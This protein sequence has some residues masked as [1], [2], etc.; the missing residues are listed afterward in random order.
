MWPDFYQVVVSNHNICLV[1]SRENKF[2]FSVSLSDIFSH[3]WDFVVE[4]EEVALTPDLN[5]NQNKLKCRASDEVRKLK[6]FKYHLDFYIGLWIG[7]IPG[8]IPSQAAAWPEGHGPP[9]FCCSWLLLKLG[10]P[11]KP[12]LEQS[13]GGKARLINEYEM[14]GT[15]WLIWPTNIQPHIFSL[16][17]AHQEGDQKTKE[18]NK[19]LLISITYILCYFKVG[20]IKLNIYLYAAAPSV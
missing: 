1:I 19:R 14:T 5:T 3:V 9:G 17:F 16:K 20:T 2:P 11:W 12:G 7:L 18:I 6:G 10:V 13:G 4:D 15:G 8:P